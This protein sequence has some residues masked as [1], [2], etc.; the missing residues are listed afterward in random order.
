MGG[1]QSKDS[2]KNEN[3]EE[4]IIA[5]TGGSLEVS[6][7]IDRLELIVVVMFVV[8]FFIGLWYMLKKCK[9]NLRTVIRQEVRR[10]EMRR[11]ASMDVL[12]G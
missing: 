3:K 2:K 4:V 8:I 6:Q 1:S 10:E 11:S 9:K 12:K 5:Q 7:S